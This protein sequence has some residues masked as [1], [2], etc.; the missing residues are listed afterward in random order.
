MQTNYS[1]CLSSGSVSP[2]FTAL[3]TAVQL[4]DSVLDKAEETS[5]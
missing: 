4:N 1:V 5:H 2:S 3:T